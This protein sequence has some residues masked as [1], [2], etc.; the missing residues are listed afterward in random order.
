MFVIILGVVG[1]LKACRGLF[2]IEIMLELSEEQMRGLKYTLNKK[3]KHTYTL[4]HR[5]YMEDEVRGMDGLK[6]GKS[7]FFSFC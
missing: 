1:M 6:K 7:F 4:V 2:G 5:G 3:K